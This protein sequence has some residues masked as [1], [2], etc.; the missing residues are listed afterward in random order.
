MMNAAGSA[1]VTD[2]YIVTNGFTFTAWPQAYT[3]SVSVSRIGAQGLA[4]V[5]T[6]NCNSNPSQKIYLHGGFN[7]AGCGL[8]ACTS[9]H[10]MDLSDAV[11]TWTLVGISNVPA[12]MFASTL[13]NAGKWF[14]CG[15]LSFNGVSYN[16]QQDCWSNTK[17]DAAWTS[18]T[19]L[20]TAI[21]SAASSVS[22]SGLLTICGGT[23][24]SNSVL[25]SCYTSPTGVTW[26]TVNPA[27]TPKFSKWIF[28]SFDF[29]SLG[30]GLNTYLNVSYSTLTMKLFAMAD[31]TDTS[32]TGLVYDI[33]PTARTTFTAASG[34]QVLRSATNAAVLSGQNQGAQFFWVNVN[35]TSCFMLQGG[36]GTASTLRW[37]SFLFCA[38]DISNSVPL[39]TV[40]TTAGSSNGTCPG[41]STGQVWWVGLQCQQTCA[42]NYCVPVTAPGNWSTTPGPPPANTGS[43]IECSQSHTSYTCNTSSLALKVA[44]SC[45]CRQW[46]HARRCPVLRSALL[47]AHHRVYP[48]SSTRASADFLCLVV[49]LFVLAHRSSTAA[50]M[51]PSTTRFHLSRLAVPS[52][53]PTE[54]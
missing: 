52:E 21:Y 30:Y 53:L 29:S 39:P 17:P 43:T 12:R 20:P 50:A 49:I 33:I 40:P 47:P 14:I 41:T 13:W 15:G 24:G 48:W 16:V 25:T 31:A 6:G 37:D 22:S 34:S 9:I 19:N 11:P 10:V 28:Q 7:G 26:T 42:A 44:C 8:S 4:S 45:V 1:L 18:I 5:V 2:A 32:I 23:T 3:G 54:R 27:P 35:N 36:L 46:L 51:E 38:S